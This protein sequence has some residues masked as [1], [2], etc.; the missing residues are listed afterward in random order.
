MQS[1]E[2][3]YFKLF[4]DVC[5]G[6]NSSLDLEEVLNLITENIVTALDVKACTVFLWDK[7]RNTLEV[8]SAC[9]LSE[10]YLKK[11]QLD[12]DKSIAETLE[13]EVVTIL[14]PDNDPRVQYPA[15]A[16]SEGIASFLSVP[17]FVKGQIIGVLRIYT[18]EKRYFSDDECELIC[19]LSDMGGIAIDN[20]RMYDHLKADHEKLI[21][22]THRWFEFGK[23]T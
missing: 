12:A 20:A 2:L 3:Q 17:I 22:E 4:R 10:E 23:A 9:G 18:A 19:G 6:I 21:D 14:D 16:K 7:K 11:G 5:K 1:K 8:S 15:E 13:G